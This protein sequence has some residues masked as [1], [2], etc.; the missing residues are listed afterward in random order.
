M[1]AHCNTPMH[2]CI[3]HC[4]PATTGECARP[5]HAADEYIHHCEGDKTVMRPFAKLLWSLVITCATLLVILKLF[6]NYI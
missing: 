5:E 6:C 4:L 3:S 1:P 2:K